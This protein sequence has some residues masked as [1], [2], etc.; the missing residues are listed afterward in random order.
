MK[1]ICCLFLLIVGMGQARNVRATLF[2][3]IQDLS[4]G[5]SGNSISKDSLI[6]NVERTKSGLMITELK[7][8]D[9][10]KYGG[11]WDITEFDKNYYYSVGAL[12]IVYWMELDWK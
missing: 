11:D 7:N 8:Y 4:K 3:D 12:N 10:T 9:G 5:G 1:K 2:Q 6:V